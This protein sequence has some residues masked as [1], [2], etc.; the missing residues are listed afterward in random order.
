M[1]SKQAKNALKLCFDSKS[2]EFHH[3]TS[4][5]QGWKASNLSKSID[6][7]MRV[8]PILQ[9]TEMALTFIEN[10]LSFIDYKLEEFH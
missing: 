1:F 7:V 5:K 4:E 2:Q 9:V 8:A 6:L 3:C 10:N